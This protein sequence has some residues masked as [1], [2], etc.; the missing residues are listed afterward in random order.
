MK[1]IFKA[2]APYAEDALN[3]PVGNVETAVPYY[4]KTFGF[5]VVSR[6]DLPHR[7][8]ILARDDVQIGLAENGGDPSQEGCFFE[9]ENLEA[10]FAEIK[11][12]APT[13]TSFGDHKFGGGFFRAF[14]E[15]GPD[16]L[17]YLIG[18]RQK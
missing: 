6:Q 1:A 17:C 9:V 3:L 2:T 7:K 12:E 8:V 15:V 14:F 16:G 4:E 18:E 11:G 5:R 10:A 13:E